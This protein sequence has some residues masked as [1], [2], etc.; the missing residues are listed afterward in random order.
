MIVRLNRQRKITVSDSDS[1]TYRSRRESVELIAGP[2]CFFYSSHDN[3][4]A[5]ELAEREKM[6]EVMDDA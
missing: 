3:A 5:I 1:L 2:T 6:I 4:H